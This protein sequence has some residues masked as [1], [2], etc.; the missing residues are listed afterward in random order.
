MAKPI[1]DTPILWGNDA[2]DFISKINNAPSQLDRDKERQ[3]IDESLLEFKR[4]I[5]TLNIQ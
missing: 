2:R 4:L 3:R 5:K 1:K